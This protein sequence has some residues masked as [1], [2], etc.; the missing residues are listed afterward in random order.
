MENLKG[1]G[2]WR[3]SASEFRSGRGFLL[4]ISSEPGLVDTPEK[5][6]RDPYVLRDGDDLWLFYSYAGE[7]GIGLARLLWR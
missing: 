5:Q 2:I 7:T 4:A 1:V 6:L 3:T